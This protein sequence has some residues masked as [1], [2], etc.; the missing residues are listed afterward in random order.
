MFELTL[1]TAKVVSV[2]DPDKQGKIQINI[3]PKMKGVKKELFPWAIPLFSNTS[4]N[5]LGNH[6]PKENSQVW[7]LVDKYWKRFY[8]LS[9]RYFYNLF[10]FSKAKG[11][12][13]KCDKIDKSY[14]N[15]DFTYYEDGTL[16]FHNNEDGSS[17][18]ITSSGTSLYVDKDGNFINDINNDY[19][20]NVKNNKE[21]VITKDD[22]KDVKNNGDYKYK[23][24]NIKCNNSV[25]VESVGNASFKSNA[26][27]L[28]EIGNT[29]NT[30]GAILTELC[31]D[32][33]ALKTTGSPITHTAPELS[34]QMV[35]LIA[36][37]KSVFI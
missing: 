24:L 18:I 35:S 28:V 16:V 8:Y 33:I 15:L 34:I 13:D 23:N 36:K 32:L 1:E 31:N 5:T 10:D 11:L 20:I 26:T 9:N 12:L 25:N 29:V 21:E 7:V 3:E 22:I 14:K 19:K 4:S 2:D 6:P 17:G 27:G 37:I 30:L